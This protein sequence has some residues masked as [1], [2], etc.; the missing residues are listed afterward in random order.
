V[1]NEFFTVASPVR[2][3]IEV[4]IRELTQ[5]FLLKRED[6]GRTFPALVCRCEFEALSETSRDRSQMTSAHRLSPRA[7][8]SLASCVLAIAALTLLVMASTVRAA[9]PSGYGEL[10]RFGETSGFKGHLAPEDLRARAIGVDPSDNSVYLLDEPKERENAKRFLRLQKF[11]E[12][13][14]AY[15]LKASVEFTETAPEGAEN[16]EPTVEGLAVDPTT[17]RVYLLAVDVRKNSLKQASSTAGGDGLLVASTLYAFSTTESGSELVAASGTKKGVLVG[18]AELGSQSETPGEALLQP[19]GITVDPATSEVVILAHEDKSTEKEDKVASANDHYV[20]QRIKSD[21]TLGDRYFDTKDVLKEEQEHVRFPVPDSPIV[22]SAGSKEHVYIGY[23]NGLAEIP[24]EFTSSTAPK[25]LSG[26]NQGIEG[27]FGEPSNGGELT[28]APDGTLFGANTAG[29]KN[30]EPGG[31][32]RAG[33]VALSGE[34]GEELGWTG[35][36]QL[37]GAEPKE[38]CVISPENHSLS[39]LVAAGSGGKVFVLAPEFLLREVEGE[40]EIIENEEGEIIEEIPT[41][42]SLSGPFFPPVIEFGPG[43]TGCPQAS[44]TTPVAKVNNLEVKGEEAIKR[45]SEVVFSSQL[46]QAD[47]LKVEWDFGD[48]SEKTVPGDEYQSTSVE[49]TYTSEGTFTVTEKI[50]SDDLASSGE[51]VYAGGHLT[52]PTITVTRTIL[53]GPHPPKALF[54]APGVV[55]VG[56][57]ASFVSHSTDPN[58]AEGLPLEYVWNFGDGTP[59]VTIPSPSHGYAAAG[60]YTVTLTVTDHLGLKSAFSQP[61]TVNQPG[62]GGGGN[63]EGPPPPGAT[64]AGTTTTGGTGG[65]TGTG[66]VLSYKVSLAG[67]ALSVSSAGALVL[68]VDCGGSSSCTGAVTLRTL[69][70]VSAGAGKHKAI[71]TLASGSFKIA[72][73]QVKALTLHL[74]S[75]AR[76]LLK[77]SH[78]LRARASIV[79]RDSA[80]TSHTTSL[81]VTLRAAKH[82]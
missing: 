4:A 47:A 49:H 73:D 11:T 75:K 5:R 59:A 50:Y 53:V 77:R 61:I 14:G 48:G 81:L 19:H 18:A 34:N 63:E 10:T 26:P 30:E 71:L 64:T 42:E 45:G 15:T 24:Y 38:K 33:V 78:V 54:T 52:T 44:A 82:H 28:A 58:G 46:K 68:K 57:A 66:S 25:I 80:G 40:P 17:K 55:N 16:V 31:E 20:L 39:P 7:M 72:G 3:S 27:G 8:L 6:S 21:G 2:N 36:G 43:G 56:E 12:T 60:T 1:K 74:S 35:G 22:V 51:T 65:S 32:S 67:T 70:A 23:A 13:G 9:E 41:Y 29:I 69:S 62:G 79:A 37:H 76:A